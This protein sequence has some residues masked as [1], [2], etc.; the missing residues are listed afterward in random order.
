MSII[1]LKLFWA[2]TVNAALLNSDRPLVKYLRDKM[3]KHPTSVSNCSVNPEGAGPV[4]CA[5]AAAPFG[6][7]EVQQIPRPSGSSSRRDHPNKSQRE[8]SIKYQ[9][10][11]VTANVA[12]KIFILFLIMK[13]SFSPLSPSI[14]KCVEKWQ[15]FLSYK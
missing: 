15:Q 9:N 10:W 13:Y 8:E 1:F 3:W 14:F 6:H 7:C 12:V 2:L 4:T 11:Q 5:V